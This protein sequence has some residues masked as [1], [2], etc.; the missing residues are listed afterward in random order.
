MKAT[1]FS[2]SISANLGNSGEAENSQVFGQAMQLATL[3]EVFTLQGARHCTYNQQQL[4]RWFINFR[5]ENTGS[6]S[7]NPGPRRVISSRDCMEADEKL[8]IY[9][10]ANPQSIIHVL[11]VHLSTPAHQFRDNCILK[12]LCICDF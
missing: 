12:L 4:Y 3:Q 5:R 7:S 9:S 8:C 11:Y 6:C 2:S 10:V 1:S